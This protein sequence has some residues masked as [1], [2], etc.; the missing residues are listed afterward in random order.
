[1]NNY[2]LGNILRT[3][4]EKL[5]APSNESQEIEA[6]SEKLLISIVGLDYARKH[7]LAENIKAKHKFNVI[8]V[9]KLIE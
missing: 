2:Y 6:S 1:V 9:D 7:F 5:Y 3:V 8:Y 4:F